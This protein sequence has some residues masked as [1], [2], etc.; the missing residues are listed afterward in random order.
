MRDALLPALPECGYWLPILIP[1][2][3]DATAIRRDYAVVLKGLEAFVRMGFRLRDVKLRLPHG[4]FLAWCQEWLGDL[5]SRHL[6]RAKFVA[7][8]LCEA[9]GLKCDTRV[10][11]DDI[12]PQLAEIVT[13]ASGIRH[14]MTSVKEFRHDPTE[15]AAR[16]WCESRWAGDPELRDEF[17]PLVLAGERT[18][19][20]AKI[21]MLGASQRGG[22][23]GAAD[24]P[25]LF[26]RN[27]R[28]FS[29]GW[30]HW[31]A[32]PAD[33]RETV[34]SELQAAFKAAPDEVKR[35]LQLALK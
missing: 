26:L 35:S 5:S 31:H 32:V 14:L 9:A 3:V 22:S 7:D 2:D 20:Q 4:R 1:G 34:L 27:A 23:R 15:E 18:Y 28:S 25:A 21:A 16:L 33:H 6:Q 10:A 13:G 24:Y 30:R 11:F 17:E 29:E 12:P 8:C 19:V